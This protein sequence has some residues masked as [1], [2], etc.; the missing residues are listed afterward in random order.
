VFKLLFLK[1][2]LEI[3]HE[4][5]SYII[6][7]NSSLSSLPYFFSILATFKMNQK[8]LSFLL[9][10]LLF[11]FSISS[12]RSEDVV[13]EIEEVVVVEKVSVE[14][15]QGH[16]Y[17]EGD[18]HKGHEHEL[19]KGPTII[20]NVLEKGHEYFGKGV[21][22][23]HEVVK[24]P[25]RLLERKDEFEHLLKTFSEQNPVLLMVLALIPLLAYVVLIPEKYPIKNYSEKVSLEEYESQTKDFTTQQV[26][27]L[28]RFIAANPN[29]VETTKHYK[30][31]YASNN[32]STSS[33]SE[34][35]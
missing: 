16:E 14:I 7:I 10:G 5:A 15:P 26:A 13:E 3:S 9:I 17:N 24:L 8:T 20:D 25:Q 32:T 27:D 23:A 12:T 22:Y 2:I 19:P 21:E 11:S 35:R 31:I 18:A 34:A 30:E 28:Q 6:L 4:L 29:I 33:S 1:E